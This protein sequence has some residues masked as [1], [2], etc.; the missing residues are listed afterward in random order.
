MT[1][2]AISQGSIQSIERALK[3]TELLQVSEEMGITQIATSLSLPKGTIHGII[4]T[5][6]KH[7]YL[8]QNLQ[9]KKYLLGP[10]LLKIGLVA[11]SRTDLRQLSIQKVEHLSKK[12]NLVAYASVLVRD[13]CV[14]VSH[15]I[16]KSFF[17]MLPQTGS[18]FP[19]HSTSLGKVLL[20]GVSKE[21]LENL[22]SYMSLEQ[23][24]PYTIT[25]FDMLK[26]RISEV[27]N[28]GF[29]ITHGESLMGLSCA[30]AP[31]LDHT[32]RVVAAI[33]IATNTDLL[34]SSEYL[35][36]VVSEVVK[37]GY[38]ISASLGYNPSRKA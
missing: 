25:D 38:D 30:A 11:I 9:T 24:T 10:S 4:K 15:H 34:G 12:F 28:K 21:E 33:G 17:I 3:I 5:L 19:V 23:F 6:E 27:K 20:S 31:I 18:S 1:G 22:F 2:K 14:I 29:D 36:E 13:M 35:D 16:P 37:S 26:E 8:E 32:G 7:G